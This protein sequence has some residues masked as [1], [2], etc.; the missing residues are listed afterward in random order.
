MPISSASISMA[1]FLALSVPPLTEVAGS[2]I[3]LNLFSGID[4]RFFLPNSDV[5]DF[6]SRVAISFSGL[7]GGVTLGSFLF[8]SKLSGQFS[9]FAFFI[10]GV[11]PFLSTVF[12]P[13]NG[14]GSWWIYGGPTFFVTS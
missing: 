10:S 6:L 4:I 8:V 5:A 2:T 12:A 9:N 3:S 14:T 1:G 13:V 11:L 7:F